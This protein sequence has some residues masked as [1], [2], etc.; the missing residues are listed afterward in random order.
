VPLDAPDPAPAARGDGSLGARRAAAIELAAGPGGDLGGLGLTG[1]ETAWYVARGAALRGDVR[2]LLRCLE[3]LPAG[4]YPGL[5]ELLLHRFAEISGDPEHAARAV[6]L[7]VPFG[8][9]VLEARAMRVALDAAPSRAALVVLKPYARLAGAAHEPVAA[10]VAHRRRLPARATDR[11]GPAVRVLDAC[12]GGLAGEPVADPAVLDELPPAV[13]DE[14]IR[15]G[16]IT[17]AVVPD[18]AEDP[19]DDTGGGDG[20][21]AAVAFLRY[22]LAPEAVDD[23]V[24]R[25]AGLHAELAR[26]AYLAD[27]AGQLRSLPDADAG[28]RHYRALLTYHRSGRIDKDD[29]RPEALATI[30]AADELGPPFI[31]TRPASATVAADPSCWPALRANALDEKIRIG[32]ETRIGYPRFALWLDLCALHRPLREGRW[33]D[34][35]QDARR[36]A[37]A[38]DASPSTRAEALNV[39]AYA[40]WQLRRP[41]EALR[42]LDGALAVRPSA[43][44]AINA[45][46]IAADDGAAAL[47]YLARA[48][49]H[50]RT[51]DTRRAVLA[52]AID[53]WRA[54]ARVDGYPPDLGAMVRAELAVPRP[55]D[56]YHREL[57]LLALRHDRAWLAQASLRMLAAGNDLQAVTVRYHR[58]RAGLEADLTASG[59]Y[60]CADALA[61]LCR[62]A[63]APDWVLAE[64]D[65]LVGRL[66]AA[67]R[68]D[69][70]RVGDFGPAVIALAG[71]DVLDLAERL[72]LSAATGAYLADAARQRHRAMF[73]ESERKLL[74]E[75]AELFRRS[76][77]G[78]SGEDRQQIGDAFAV[79]MP[80]ALLSVTLAARERAG[81]PQY[82]P[83][84]QRCRT[85]VELAESL[86]RLGRRDGAP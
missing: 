18:D 68:T 10:T 76:Y 31:G 15:T 25:A 20:P 14:L 85:Y 46:L 82:E 23:R 45:A 8:D 56:D 75:P 42:S 84:R 4:G 58:G 21:G 11:L 66:W 41:E 57:L 6:A 86:A 5:V 43:G 72:R 17:A 13:L 38:G 49:R 16:A 80:K 37:A 7:L 28:V 2:E 83:L 1:S 36:I 19:D 3:G 52:Q 67:L 39:L 22:R 26:R 63:P 12:V 78:L 29:L 27:D 71:A 30:L 48:M 24:L 64:R 9:G 79:A 47:P 59:L 73:P 51:P 69:F 40:Q 61:V 35:E 70:A 62:P 81:T 54:D 32:E 55:D 65:W 44:L 53:L 33:G 50:A 34:A 77:H 74:F 60:Q